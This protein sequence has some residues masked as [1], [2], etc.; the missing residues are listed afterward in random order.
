MNNIPKVKRSVKTLESRIR[1]V[2][3]DDE[4]VISGISGKFPKAKN[5]SEFADN[6]YNKV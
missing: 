3:P 6:L 4:I 5:V 2:T 1:P